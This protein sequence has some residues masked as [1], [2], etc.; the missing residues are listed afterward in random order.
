MQQ[1]LR[2]YIGNF[3]WRGDPVEGAYGLLTLR[4]RMDTVRHER[5]VAQKS[6]QLAGRFGV[7][8][9]KCDLAAA[10][11]DISVLIPPD[12]RLE[13]ATA[14]DIP[15]LR[16]E[17]Q[18]PLLLHQKL[19]AVIARQW[20]GVTD[21]EVL[22]AVSCHTTLKPGAGPLDLLIFVTDKLCW[23]GAGD[24]PYG[25]AM[26]RELAHSLERAALC[27]LRYLLADPSLLAP[28][29]WMMRAFRELSASES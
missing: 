2:P 9:E 24:P 25:A 27:Y 22:S 11:H 21:G 6:R 17:R 14:L 8:R 3:E 7:E 5:A 20:L 12:K 29:P 10:L 18:V 4:G 16:E 26:E 23:D 19:S 28:H 13:V 15:I 1:A